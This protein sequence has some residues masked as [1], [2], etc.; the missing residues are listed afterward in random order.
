MPEDRRLEASRLER[1]MA[2]GLIAGPEREAGVTNWATF[3][4]KGTPRY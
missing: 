3:N 2:E 4:G 1:V